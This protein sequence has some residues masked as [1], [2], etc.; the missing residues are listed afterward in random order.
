MKPTEMTIQE[1]TAAARNYNNIMNEGGD[2]YNPYDNEMERR[3]ANA[4]RKR[5]AE[6]AATPKGRIDALYRRI[7]RECGSVAREWGNTE[8][9]NALQNSLY[10]E[11][12][13][14]KAEMER[15]FLTVWDLE[16]TK[17]RRIEWNGFAKSTLIPMSKSG[18][19]VEMHRLKR[20]REKNQGWT[21]DDLKK[22]IKTHNL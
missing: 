4:E 10:A 3:A 8:E 21:M 15:D 1:L 7:E 12:N 14:I 9:I 19:S 13:Q 5:I 18:K 16:T 20:E 17:T 6:Y 11:I 22:A 2:G